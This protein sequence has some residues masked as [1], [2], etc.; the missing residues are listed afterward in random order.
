MNVRIALV[1]PFVAGVVLIVTPLSALAAGSWQWKYYYKPSGIEDFAGM[2]V[3]N[4]G[5]HIAALSAHYPGTKNVYISSNG[6]ASWTTP[7]SLAGQVDYV[8]NIA[9]ANPR[10]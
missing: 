3:A 10:E 9:G 2:H 1:A 6:G 8:Q 5:Q 7:L 4:D